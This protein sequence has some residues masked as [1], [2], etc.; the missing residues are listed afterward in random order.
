M[1]TLAPKCRFLSTHHHNVGRNHIGASLLIFQTTPTDGVS[2]FH[3]S[4][5]EM[6]SKTIDPA[7]SGAYTPLELAG[8]TVLQLK[9]LC[10]EKKIPG[11]SKLGKQALIEKLSSARPISAGG[12]PRTAPVDS[13]AKAPT[14]APDPPLPLLADGLHSSTATE[15]QVSKSIRNRRMPPPSETTPRLVTTNTSSSKGT[16]RPQARNTKTASMAPEEPSSVVDINSDSAIRPTFGLA[17]PGLAQSAAATMTSPVLN[18]LSKPP[19]QIPQ[20]LISAPSNSNPQHPV[21]DPCLAVSIVDT[22]LEPGRSSANKRIRQNVERMPPPPAKRPRLLPPSAI[23][24]L[25]ETIV[26][27]VPTLAPSKRFKPLV[28]DRSKLQDHSLHP[29]ARLAT[30][31]PASSDRPVAWSP[32][33]L[34]ADLELECFTSVPELLPITMPP[35]L[36]HRKRVHRWAVI[37]SGLSNTER[38]VCV[39]VSRAFRYAGEWGRSISQHRSFAHTENSLSISVVRL[40]QGIRRPST[41]GGRLVQVLAGDDEHVAIPPAARSRGFQKTPYI[42]NIFRF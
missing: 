22:S 23:P 42:R 13:R 19:S 24:S 37:L 2:L 16:T 14:L 40:V 9:A 10:K 7:V 6:P 11:Y 29:P 12:P 34:L 5:N 1:E 27:S 38:V 25:F 32:E 36:S 41:S 21:P 31:T 15:G 35:T 18:A 30:K 33:T 20:I 39:L 28:I 4:L 17:K 8:L 26:P 3:Y